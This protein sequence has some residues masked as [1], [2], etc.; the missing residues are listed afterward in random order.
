MS[1]S[2]LAR[3]FGLEVRL[4]RFQLQGAV[5]WFAQA[6]RDQVAG[7]ATYR[8]AAIER[9]EI[10]QTSEPAK[11][12]LKIRFAYLRDLD[13][14]PY[15]IPA[16]QSLGDLWHPFV[17]SDHV[18]VMCL[19]WDGSAA[20]PRMVW[21]GYVSQPQFSD[22]ELELTCH[23]NT[24]IGE[25]K[26]QGPKSQRACWKPPYSTGLDGCNLDPD[27]FYVPGA[28][29]AIDGLTMTVPAFATA[30]FS[31]LQGEFRWERTIT[32]HNGTIAITERRTISA[33]DGATAR[34]LSGGLGLAGALD[35]VGLPGC[36]GTW[37]ACAE[38]RPDPQNH[39]GGAYYKPVKNPYDGQSMSW[40]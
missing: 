10:E 20:A 36:P 22:V 24:A 5:W 4:F 21:S 17:P 8:A 3:F 35:V 26:N 23:P 25:A 34:L 7:G 39:Y 14:L 2:M 19:D 40:G 38:R 31:L 12:K 32:A 33:H 16:T 18:K 11:D 6:K 28:I 30:P 29:S 27:D 15:E 13:A 37:D 9:D 1:D